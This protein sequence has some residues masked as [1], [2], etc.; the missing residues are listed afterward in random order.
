MN[1]MLNRQI[2]GDPADKGNVIS[3]EAA[4]EILQTWVLNE[5]LRLHMKQVGH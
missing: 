5:R 3:K 4:L 2:F 1:L